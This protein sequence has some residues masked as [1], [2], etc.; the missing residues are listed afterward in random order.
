LI[1][2]ARPFLF[3]RG[4]IVGRFVP[5]HRGH[6]Y[7]IDVGCAQSRQ[8]SVIVCKRPN[9]SPPSELRVEWM[10]EIHPPVNVLTVDDTDNEQY[11]SVWA[12]NAVSVLGFVPDVLFSSEDYGEPFARCLGCAHVLVDK[13]R[14]TVPISGTKVRSAPLRYWEFLEPPVR[15]WYALRVCV[16]GAESTWKTTLAA[17]LADHYQTHWVA[18]YAREYCERKLAEG[19]QDWS[20]AEFVHIA[21]IQNE[22]EH[23]AARQ[24][25]RILLCDTDAWATGIWYRRY[26]NVRSPE[27]EAIAAQRK[28]PDLYLLMDVDTPFERDSIRDGEAIRNW[29]HETFL[30]ELKLQATPFA[31]LSGT[32]A[33]RL[34]QAVRRI[35]ALLLE[36]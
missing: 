11:Y 3:E 16:V 8:L 26:F 23:S 6:K 2:Q 25:N 1:K 5:P 33:D 24:A 15:A 13:P 7:L 36:G 19:S 27:V 12:Q 22:R 31:V 9:E 17:A 29:M 30:A 21:T 20:L 34:A 18:E 10:R 4:L 35:N 32:H 14:E 28:Q